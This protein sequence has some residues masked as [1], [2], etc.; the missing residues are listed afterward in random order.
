MEGVAG[1]KLSLSSRLLALSERRG[2]RGGG[3]VPRWVLGEGFPVGC[4]GESGKRMFGAR[5]AK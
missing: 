3:L 1:G 2:R 5:R 4:G